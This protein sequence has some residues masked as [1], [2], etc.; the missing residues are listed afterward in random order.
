[1]NPSLIGTILKHGAYLTLI[2]S[3]SFVFAACASDQKSSV[4]SQPT[5][6]ETPSKSYS[7]VPE[8]SSTAPALSGTKIDIAMNSQTTKIG[9]SFKADIAISNTT[10]LR[11]AQWKLNFNPRV[12]QLKSISE[13][14]F[15]KDW[16]AANNGT[17]LILPKPEIDNTQGVVSYMGIAVMS[18]IPGGAK[19]DGIL[20]TYNFVALA[21]LLE[22]PVIS[23]MF[24]CDIDGNAFSYN[25]EK[26]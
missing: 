15:F 1:M 20:C 18:S 11:G 2:L 14:S 24:L 9:D 16:A 26:H 5:L 22:V 21:D 4:V 25:M 7:L 13:G 12:M 10:A 6:T 17:T 19:G 23:D 3:I 8:I